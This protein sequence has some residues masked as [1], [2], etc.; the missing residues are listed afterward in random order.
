MLIWKKYIGVEPR[1]NLYKN[2]AIYNTT[3]CIISIC[4]PLE[5]AEHLISIN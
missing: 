2:Y 4:I 5:P 3:E 1:S